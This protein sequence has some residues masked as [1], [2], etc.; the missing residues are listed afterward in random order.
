MRDLPFSNSPLPRGDRNSELK[1]YRARLAARFAPGVL[2]FGL[3]YGALCLYTYLDKPLFVNSF[4]YFE[5]T[6]CIPDWSTS[7]SCV[8]DAAGNTFIADYRSNI[9]VLVK[10]PIESRA[11]VI[12][13]DGESARILM[14][15][16]RSIQFAVKPHTFTEIDLE[17]LVTVSQLK[18]GKAEQWFRT[19][20][21]SELSDKSAIVT[22]E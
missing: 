22:S 4:G 17:G 5:K 8:K 11:P 10:A 2:L 12:S 16:G 1:R 21:A 18:P 19:V 14:A 13:E 20:E 3:L 6:G 15:D 7:R 9:F